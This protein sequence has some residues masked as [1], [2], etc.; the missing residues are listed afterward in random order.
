MAGG[1]EWELNA[2]STNP[3]TPPSPGREAAKNGTGEGK[4][5]RRLTPDERSRLIEALRAGVEKGYGY[6]RI[7]RML[8]ESGIIVSGKT[9]Q[10]WY[11]RRY[12]E[13]VRRR[14][15][16]LP[17]ELR[18][19]LYEK[20]LELRR[21]GLGYWRIRRR[22]EEL[23]GVVLSPSVI[24]YW[25]LG[26]HT[27][28]NGI[29]IPTIDHLEPSPE[30][31]YVIGVVSGDG[32][33]YKTRSGEYEVGARVKDRDFIEEFSR[34]SGRVLGI[35]PPKPIP[36]VDGQFKVRVQSKVLYQ[37]LQKPI[38]IKRI[39]PFIGHCEDCM[40]SFLRGFFDGEG[41]VNKNGVILCY[42]TDT[43][44]LEYV[45]RLLNRLGI[46]TTG[47]RICTRR[48]TP[49]L[50]KKLGKIYK[51]RKDLYCIYVKMKDRLRFYRLI[52]FTIQRKQQRLQ[53][54]LKRRGLLDT[55][56]NQTLP[57]PSPPPPTSHNNEKS[58][59]RVESFA[60]CCRRGFRR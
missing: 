7:W 41:S 58:V 21:A 23:Y 8:R 6:M 11:Y 14:G 9:V 39:K 54:H 55:P 46:E 18:I 1:N 5:R 52:G 43:K 47:P 10:Y 50:N 24:V 16:Y 44:L 51:R 42:N 31:A 49:F 20:V 48:G 19:R 60:R 17:R 56:P 34:C 40:R 35:E 30:L 38:D 36:V 25:C 4:T 3:T 57:Q 53:E 2:P 12:P 28:Y 32:W 15:G 37:L 29:R 45:Q 13:K 33:T 27:P 59:E 22:I 26:V